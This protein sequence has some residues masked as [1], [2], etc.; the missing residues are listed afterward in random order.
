MHNQPYPRIQALS[1]SYHDKAQTG[2]LMTR[3]TS[4][5]DLVQMFVSQGFLM[6]IGSV[7]MMIGSIV[8]LFVTN[9]RLSL[10]MLV[11]APVTFG[12]FGWVNSKIHPMFMLVQ[13]RLAKLNTVLQESLVGVR[14]VQ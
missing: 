11:I 10:V 14:V 6:V 7:L 4:D 2:Q 9:W 5:V 8:L 1:F 3:V 12:V 13:Q